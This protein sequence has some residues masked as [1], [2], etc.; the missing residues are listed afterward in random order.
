MKCSLDV[1][2]ILARICC[3]KGAL[4]QGSSSSPI[5]SYWAYSEMWDEI[6]EIAQNAGNIFTLYIDDLSLSGNVV[7][8]KTVW[9]SGR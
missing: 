2:V 1:S 4:P 6:H 5:L 8:K 9:K 7:S 3:D